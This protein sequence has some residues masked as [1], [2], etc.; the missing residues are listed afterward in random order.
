MPKTLTLM[1]H[2]KSSWEYNLQDQFR[3][4]KNRAFN[5]IAL[6]FSHFKHLLNDNIVFKSS[7]AVRAETTAREFLK[8][9]EI[10]TEKLVVEPSLYTFDPQRL[11]QFILNQGEEIDELMIFGHNPAFTSIANFY[12]SEY[13][14]NVPTAGLVQL[15]FN[16]DTWANIKS[17]ETLLHLFPKQLK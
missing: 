4:L 5:D 2:G 10:S 11:Q 17:A 13:F 7:H 16:S 14:D 12:G 6:V 8:I 3:P 1:R 9:A 15:K